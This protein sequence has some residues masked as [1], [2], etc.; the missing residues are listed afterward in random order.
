[1]LTLWDH[2]LA[3]REGLV[4]LCVQAVIS[5]PSGRG[6]SWG[7]CSAPP[8]SPP[9]HH[10]RAQQQGPVGHLGKKS[11]AP[12]ARPVPSVLFRHQPRAETRAFPAP[13]GCVGCAREQVLA[14]P[15]QLLLTL[16][17]SPALQGQ[18]SPGTAAIGASADDPASWGS[19]A[20]A[21]A[22]ATHPPLPPRPL[23]PLLGLP[24]LMWLICWVP[25]AAHA[26]QWSVAVRDGQHLPECFQGGPEAGLPVHPNDWVHPS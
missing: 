19:L 10:T 4:K 18:A 22:G 25:Q 12:L 21:V 15:C 14:V 11:Q 26:G 1:M 24:L 6:L 9:R 16:P 8:A 13:Q 17:P 2:Q 23:W 5:P 3:H 20:G 7:G